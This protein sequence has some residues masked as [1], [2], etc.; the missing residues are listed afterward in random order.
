MKLIPYGLAAMLATLAV[1]MALAADAAGERQLQQAIDLMERGNVTKASALFEQ[2][3]HRSDSALA[4]RALLYLA[5]AQERQGREQA[6]ATYARIVKDFAAQ[7]E[8]AAQARQRLTELA[9]PQR[10]SRPGLEQIASGEE[11]DSS[12]HI[13]PDGHF[14]ARP[15]W[16]TGDLI[17]KDMRSGRSQRMK[18]KRGD[19]DTSDQEVEEVMVSND[20]KTI[21]Y[22]FGADRVELRTMPNEPGAQSAPLF[23]SAEYSWYKLIGWAPDN[24]SVFVVLQG[25]DNWQIAQIVLAERRAHVLKSLQRRA[26]TGVF[27]LSPDGRFVA[28]PLL[29]T[30]RARN[31]QGSWIASSPNQH[32]YLLPTDGSGEETPLA[33]GDFIDESPVWAPDGKSIVFVSNQDGQFGLW[34]VPVADGRPVGSAGYVS[35]NVSGRIQPIA[36]THDGGFY[37]VSESVRAGR[38]VGSDIYVASIAPASVRATGNRQRLSAAHVDVNQS[39]SWSPDG[40]WVAFL[41]RDPA[42]DTVLDIGLT[43]QAFD[44]IARNVATGEEKQLFVPYVSPNGIGTF[45][46][47]IWLRD[48]TLLIRRD[49]DGGQL[50]HWNLKT[51]VAR[52]LESETHWLLP[53]GWQS[54]VASPDGRSLYLVVNGSVQGSDGPR[55]PKQYVVTYDMSD[56]SVRPVWSPT[57]RFCGDVKTPDCYRPLRTL[58]LSP[59]GRM[60][61]TIVRHIS[62]SSRIAIVG[63]DGS[64]YRELPPQVMNTMVAWSADSQSVLAV[65]EEQTGGSLIRVSA[66]TGEVAPSG[67]SLRRPA[68]AVFN[69]NKDGG[70][71]FSDRSRDVDEKLWAY[72]G[73]L[74]LLK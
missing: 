33:S 8:V 44:V 37:F 15:D 32:I 67:L 42:R 14:L 50:W 63:V 1:T 64:G 66:K 34:S 73:L 58:A 25:S 28:Y 59:D 7:K 55:T 10:R 11:A 35:A 61:A 24:R 49:Y 31:P 22:V 68:T 70:V 43:V 19:Y 3:S 62:S 23:S 30:P 52:S 60:L 48:G 74:S 38:I 40:Q 29:T 9:L 2:L 47:P 41:R 65:K 72:R 17:V 69:V 27:S 36:I 46:V 51:G 56:G 54:A 18:A 26:G 6:R 57:F 4:A 20:G 39:P 12:A 13:T 71:V 53:Q 5:S 16:T 45:V 21:V